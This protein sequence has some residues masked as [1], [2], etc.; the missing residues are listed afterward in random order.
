MKRSYLTL[1]LTDLNDLP[2]MNRWLFK[3]HA[4]DTVSQN[5]PILSRYTTYRALPIPEGAERYGAYNWRM[6]EHYWREDPF[7]ENQLDHGTAMSE[8]W[9]EGYNE[10]V[11]NPAESKQRGDWGD[12][13]KD[14]KAHPPA[15]VFCNHRPDNSFKGQGITL[16]EGPF[17]RFVVTFKYPDGV[18]FEKGEE[19][20]LSKC[21][22]A[23]CEQEDLL[24]AFSYKAVPPYTGP[25]QRVLE[26]WYRDSKTWKRNWVDKVPAI[27]RPEWA[28]TDAVP[29]LEP[30]KD[31]VC[32]FLEESP[33]RDFLN[34][35]QPYYVTA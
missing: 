31:I 28:A 4:P 33:E 35:A 32:I 20:L 2:K 14:S 15:F 10:A 12:A 24:R 13:D 18:P 22:P 30:Y 16:N 7:G 1:N 23:I 26:L 9:C 34:G 21:M 6:T 27:P 25:F 8:I 3:D 17:Y 29:Y 19:W 5:G 11:G